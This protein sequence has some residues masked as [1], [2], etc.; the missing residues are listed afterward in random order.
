MHVG[1]E[2][3]LR[4]YTDLSFSQLINTFDPTQFDLR[5]SYSVSLTTIETHFT[6]FIEAR[7][8]NPVL[9]FKPVNNRF[10]EVSNG[11]TRKLFGDFSLTFLTFLSY[12]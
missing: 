12:S 1:I 8:L 2:A 11:Q 4:K 3:D 5:C 10:T 9:G 7:M 6:G